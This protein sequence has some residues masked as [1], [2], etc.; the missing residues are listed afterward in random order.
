[1]ELLH[2]AADAEVETPSDAGEDTD[3]E[4]SAGLDAGRTGAEQ[5]ARVRPPFFEL[6]A[7]TQRGCSSNDDCSP[8]D[9]CFMTSCSAK[10]GTCTPRPPF[11]S[12]E[13][14]PEICGCDGLHYFNDCLRLYNGVNVDP[15]CLLLRPCSGSASCPEH[16]FCSYTYR[17]QCRQG[18]PERSCWV[19]PAQCG[20]NTQGGD[21]FMSCDAPSSGP[22]SCV[23][24]CEAIKSEIAYGHVSRSC[25][26]PRSGPSG[27]DFMP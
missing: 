22:D 2:F 11:C 8:R 3:M 19:M 18:P 26:P 17:S 5:D 12:G 7:G 1:V 6:D 16:A 10:R 20:P 15:T 14:G 25:G 24:A 21:L 9:Y 4:P 13:Q 23:S 27:I